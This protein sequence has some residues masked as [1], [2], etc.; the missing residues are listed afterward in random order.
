VS[1]FDVIAPLLL[2]AWGGVLVLWSRHDAR[3]LHRE[4]ERRAREKRPAE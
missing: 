2:V 3:Q 4:L 1:L